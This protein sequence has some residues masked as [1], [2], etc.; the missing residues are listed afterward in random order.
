MHAPKKK[1]IL[2]SKRIYRNNI[3][4]LSFKYKIN[5][6]DDVIIIKRYENVSYESDY[7]VVNNFTNNQ[8]WERF[9]ITLEDV[10]DYWLVLEM[11]GKHGD[12]WFAVDDISI[13][14]TDCDK[15]EGNFYPLICFV[16]YMF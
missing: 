3:Q 4:C 14:N 7:Y 6:N 11:N 10:G 16:S 15:I 5:R 2:I 9:A 13:L 8:K 1:S 12:S